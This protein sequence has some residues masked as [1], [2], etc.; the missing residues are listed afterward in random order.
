MDTMLGEISSSTSPQR[1]VEIRR[2]GGDRVRGS[3]AR[4]PR[5]STQ[6]SLDKM[7]TAAQRTKCAAPLSLPDLEPSSS[8]QLL[9][10]IWRWIETSELEK[11][12]RSSMIPRI[13]LPIVDKQGPDR[14][15]MAGKTGPV[16]LALTFALAP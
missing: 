9:L 13:Y 2:G 5:R 11:G 1:Q 7:V 16:V 10:L 12:R 14:N 4:C 8:S 15:A 6:S 3:G